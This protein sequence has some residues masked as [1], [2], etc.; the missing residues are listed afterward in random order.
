[1]YAIAVLL[2]ALMP[3]T[4]PT[5]ADV[6]YKKIAITEPDVQDA[7]KVVFAKRKG[8]LIWAERHSISGDN[9]RLCVSMNRSSSYEFARVVLSRDTKKKRWNVDVWSWGSCGR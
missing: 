4:T 3:Q 7:V 8:T 5:I 6:P 1:M 9:L 2:L